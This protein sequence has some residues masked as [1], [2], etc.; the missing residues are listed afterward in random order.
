[1]LHSATLA[2][3]FGPTDTAK[4]FKSDLMSQFNMQTDKHIHTVQESSSVPCS[5]TAI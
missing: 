3:T 2:S 1:M 5:L 4:G